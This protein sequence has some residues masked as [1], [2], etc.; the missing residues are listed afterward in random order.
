MDKITLDRIKTLHPKIR[1][2]VLDAYIF[3]NNKLLGKGVR[4]RF[5]YT[6]RTIDEQCELYKIGRT[7]L[8]DSNGKRLGKVTNAKGGESIHNYHLAWDIVLLLDKDG[9]GKFESA[10]WDTVL[11]FDKDKTSDWME[12]VKHFKSIGAVWGGDWKFKDKPHF[13]ITLGHTW[14]TLKTKLDKGDTFT[15]VING[16]K[17]TYVNL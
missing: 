7:K 11:D 17:Y 14:R 1:Q 12:V 3:C 16:V 10:S 2:K 4:L 8:Y 9:D 5:A 13:E 6:T 15:E